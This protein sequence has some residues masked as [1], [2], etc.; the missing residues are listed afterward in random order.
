MKAVDLTIHNYRSIH[1]AEI[2]L[3]DY[4]LLTGANNAGKS[5]VVNAIRAFYEKDG[6]KYNKSKDYP[7]DLK[8]DKDK[9]SWVEVTYKLTEDEYENLKE[10]YKLDGNRLKVR[11]IFDSKSFKN[12]E[13]KDGSGALYAQLKSGVLHNEPFYGAKG[14]QN[15]KIGDLIFIPAISKIDDY[16]KTTG[17]SALRDLLIGILKEVEGYEENFD[18]LSASFN[19]FSMK[20]QKSQT[21]DG[22]SLAKAE[23]SLNSTTLEWGINFNLKWSPPDINSIIKNMINPQYKDGENEISI[24]DC[25]S[26]FQRQ[27]V[28]SLIRTGA[29][30]ASRKPKSKKKEF[31]PDLEWIIFEEPEAF[32]HPPQQ[33]DLARNLR[34]LTGAEAM[35]VL[36]TTHS[37]HFVS[38]DFSKVTGTARIAKENQQSTVYQVSEKQWEEILQ[39]NSELAKILGQDES[40]AV[41]RDQSET[42]QYSLYMNAN[43]TMMF[44]SPFVLLV[45][46]PTEQALIDTLID[47]GRIKLPQGTVVMDTMGKYNMHRFIKL[48]DFLGVKHSVVYDLDDP[49]IEKWN[50]I[51]NLINDSKNSHTKQ[52]L[53]LDPDIEQWFGLDKVKESSRKPFVM[54]RNYKEGLLD[55]RLDDFI[56]LVEGVFDD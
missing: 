54:M 25:G 34:N 48:L 29:E 35:Q 41:E 5:T 45:E 13:G 39:K 40:S 2:I 47:E 24:E 51:N 32:L 3:S 53:T 17:P 52:I 14:V 55:S 23:E 12:S 1:H 26:G 31:S 44:F 18:L 20:L 21:I 8:N 36:A 7:F 49:K 22:R 16:T 56:K 9:E 38:K 11:R 43:R 27:L 37:S 42:I 19:E 28:Y 50:S 6:F 33:N 10:E 4:F 46:G 15:G 30:F